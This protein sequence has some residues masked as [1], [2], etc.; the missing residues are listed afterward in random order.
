[1]HTATVV[2]PFVALYAFAS[3][4]VSLHDDGA[5][6]TRFRGAAGNS[7]LSAR[8]HPDSWSAEDNVA[9]SVEVPGGGWSSPVVVGDKVFVTTAIQPGGET[10]KGMSGGLSSPMSRGSGGSRPTIEVTFAAQCYDLGDGTL[11]WSRELGA[12]VPE[13]S[14][15]PS[16][17][18]A[19]ETP[20]TDGERLFL[21]FGALGAVVCLDLAGTELWRVETGVH[22]TGNDFGWGISLLTDDGRVFCQNDN[23]ESSFLVALDAETGKELWRAE[24]GRGTSWGTPILWTADGGE[25]LVACGRD[26]VIAY[27]PE[28][29][30]ELWRVQG[31]GGSFSSSPTYDEAHV[32]FGNSGPM[33]KGPLIA[34]PSDA[35]GTLDLGAAEAPPI[36]WKTDRAG[37]GFPSPVVSGRY[38]YVLGS[39]SIL[40]CYDS[41]TGEE[42]YRERLPDAGTIVACPWIAGDELFVL[43]EKGTT[44]VVRVGE[45]F[46]LLRTNQLDGTYWSTPSVAGESLLL[47]A[48]DRLHCLREKE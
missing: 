21:T 47:R 24:R 36:A 27:A 16:N 22:K 45:E 32:Y 23:E 1:M 42:I 17:T 7:V 26:T 28:S 12:R 2:G 39:P 31:I 37:P 20:T 25:Q 44:Y 15:H 11:V 5:S 18:Y 43:D 29:G 9:W 8:D 41:G 35:K 14:V 34:V 46:E 19:T 3:L 30:E 40:A 10:G 38:L 48:S 33:S 13:Y 6:W 4:P